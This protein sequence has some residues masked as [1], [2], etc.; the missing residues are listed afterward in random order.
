MISRVALDVPLPKLVRTTA[1]RTRPAPTSAAGFIVRSARKRLVGLIVE[2][3]FTPK[4]RA[5]AFAPPKKSCARCRRS[6]TSGR[7]GE[8]LQRY[9]QRPRARWSRPA[10][11]AAAARASRARG[12]SALRHHA[13]RNRGASQRLPAPAAAACGGCSERLSQGT[14]PAPELAADIRGARALIERGAAGSRA[15]ELR[16]LEPRF[17]KTLSPTRS[18]SKPS[19]D[20]PAPRDISATCFYGV[21]GSGRPRSI[22]ALIAEVLALGSGSRSRARDRPY[23]RPRGCVPEPLRGRVIVIRA[24]PCR[25]PSARAAGCWRTET[26]ATSCWERGSR[27]LLPSE[28]RPG[29]RGRRQDMSFQTA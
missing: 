5:R 16:R 20:S 17:C 12:A 27:C 7:I 11:A 19:R 2:W 3:R 13:R 28:T 9:Y 23:P 18:R 1:R 14:V 24:A 29:R 6:A 25:R 22:F 4:C 15:V 21:T 8:I 26:R 10:P